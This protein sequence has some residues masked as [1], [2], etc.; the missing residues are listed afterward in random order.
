MSQ[1]WPLRTGNR[2]IVWVQSE[3]CEAPFHHPHSSHTCAKIIV[4]D[5]SEQ[6]TALGYS[7]PCAFPRIISFYGEHINIITN[8]VVIQ[9]MSCVLHDRDLIPGKCLDYFLSCHLQADILQFA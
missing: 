9:A 7:V 6:P 4:M 2:V 1:F 5:V 3:H 8:I